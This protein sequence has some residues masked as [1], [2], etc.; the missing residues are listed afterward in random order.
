MLTDSSS[1]RED[2]ADLQMENMDEDEPFDGELD[3]SPDMEVDV[4]G[5]EDQLA[6]HG[7]QACSS[8]GL[9]IAEDG[10]TMPIFENGRYQNPWKTWQHPRLPNLFKLLFCSTKDKSGLPGKEVCKFVIVMKFVNN[11]NTSIKLI[12]L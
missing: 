10:I 1:Y 7:S 8:S 5:D 9:S 12:C 2:K 4:S 6:S 11:Q 3:L